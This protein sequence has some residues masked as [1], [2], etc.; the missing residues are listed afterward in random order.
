ML[1]LIIKKKVGEGGYVRN[2]AILVYRTSHKDI[3]EQILL[4]N[5]NV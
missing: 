2:D 5:L 3:G 4:T 1:S